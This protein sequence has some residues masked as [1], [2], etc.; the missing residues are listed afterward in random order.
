MPGSS[1]GIEKTEEHESDVYTSCNRFPW[2]SHGR[3]IK[4]TGGLE[5]K[6]TNR[7]H[8]NNY[9]SEIG[10]NIEKS[11]VDLK[12]LAVTRTTEKDNQLTLT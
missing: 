4:G 5:S 6:R 7:N 12:G 3:I 8:P 1:Q 9:L 11:L 2:Y 10:Q